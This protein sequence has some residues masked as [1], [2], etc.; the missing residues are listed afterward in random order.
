MISQ[1]LE[2][3]LHAAFAKARQDRHEFITVEHLL[4]ALLDNASAAR[5]LSACSTNIHALSHSLTTFTM[6]RTPLLSIGHDADPQP[7]LGLQR[8]IQRALHGC[9]SPKQGVTGADVVLAIFGEKDS[10]AVAFM[11]SS[12][13]THRSVMRFALQGQSI[14][15]DDLLVRCKEVQHWES[16]GLATGPAL[17][18]LG[19]ALANSGGQ[20]FVQAVEQTKREAMQFVVAFGLMQDVDAPQN[21]EHQSCAPGD[22]NG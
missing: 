22:S 15:A 13:V 1:H 7:T 11:Q 21:P 6:E 2:A 18:R 19:A 10:H 12:G 5:L 17:K 4:L 20:G 14:G 3:S 9:E 16:T 8:V